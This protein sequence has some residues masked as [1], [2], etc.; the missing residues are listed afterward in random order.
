MPAMRKYVLVKL[1]W[2]EKRRAEIVT[3][4]LI[5]PSPVIIWQIS[6]VDVQWIV[7]KRG[8][9]PGREMLCARR[10]KSGIECQI[11]ASGENCL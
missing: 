1:K 7:G 6:W 11:V 5:S 10:S 4:A 2:V 8:E 3:A 9:R